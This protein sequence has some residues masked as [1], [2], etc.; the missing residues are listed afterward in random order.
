L[1]QNYCIMNITTHLK[2]YIWIPVCVGAAFRV[3]AQMANPN[4]KNILVNSRLEYAQPASNVQTV[5]YPS[6][7]LLQTQINNR[8][9]NL[10]YTPN[11][12]FIG[13]DKFQIV[14]ANGSNDTINFNVNV[15][16]G[17]ITAKDDYVLTT[18]NQSVIINVLQ[19]DVSLANAPTLNALPL[20]N[21]GTAYIENNQIRFIPKVGFTGTAHVQYST[22]N[23]LNQ[24]ATG[25]LHV[26]V[27]P[28]TLPTSTVSNVF[29]TNGRKIIVTLPAT[30][31][32]VQTLP[33]SGALRAI[34][35]GI[36]E[37]TPTANFIGTDQM[38]FQQSAN[39]TTKIH[40]VQAEVLS[41]QTPRALRDDYAY[42]SGSRAVTVPVLQNDG[43][44]ATT[45]TSISDI[46]GGTATINAA[47]NAVIFSPD[48]NFSGDAGFKY[49]VNGS[50]EKAAAHVLSSA[51][52]PIA[53]SFRL[54]AAA[55]VPLV[56]NYKVP[57]ED[58]SFD[59]VRSAGRGRVEYFESFNGQLGGETVQGDHLLVYTPNLNSELDNFSIN[60]CVDGACQAVQLTI[61]IADVNNVSCVG[62]CVWAGDANADGIVDMA[63]I[64]TIS[65]AMGEKGIART[66][67]D[68]VWLPRKASNWTQNGDNGNNLKHAD[69]NGDGLITA[70]D[71]VAVSQFWGQKR[72][73]VAQN[74]GFTIDNLELT[75]IP[76][77]SAL[78]AGDTLLLY[79]SVPNAALNTSGYQFTLGYNASWVNPASLSVEFANQWM[80]ED[81]ATLGFYRTSNQQIEVGL[82]VA[83]ARSASGRGVVGI[84]R[85][86]IEEDVT[87]C[88]KTSRYKVELNF[89]N[90]WL[91][92]ESGIRLKL[93]T[94]N[95]T[96]PIIEKPKPYLIDNQLAVFPNPATD[97]LH[98]YLDDATSFISEITLFNL[99]GQAMMQ[100]QDLQTR[101]ID[102]KTNELR[103][104]MY[105]LRAKTTTG[106]LTKK[107]NIAK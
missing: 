105:L 9:L 27:A 38:T 20:V 1:C 29:T 69:T 101:L 52:A 89:K 91:Q 85:G 2:K 18:E 41:A 47:Q 40:I 76:A 39:G 22:C 16:K 35:A 32:S 12:D 96:I 21:F 17:T 53:P 77:Q 26:R 45:L 8:Q 49:A 46:K 25:Q 31:F 51:F 14:A 107:I 93:K 57:I 54:K 58:Y 11:L 70:A 88:A 82:G 30:D 34:E 6:H 65:K 15:T 72:A 81:A 13:Q 59:V 3:Q 4:N 60:Y 95:V 90:A 71:T 10:I 5:V 87:C 67:N 62:D 78:H 19:N 99:T 66:E 84:L 61:D 73:I 23:E 44:S 103:N 94:N 36:F 83:A 100:Q 42:T 74:E 7:G 86:I 50:S 43:S 37:Y 56:L 33:S 92:T 104:G 28:K 106:Y 55:G 80:N 98:V 75:A 68:P 64:L 63:D 48:P 24:C 97:D 102:L 79:L